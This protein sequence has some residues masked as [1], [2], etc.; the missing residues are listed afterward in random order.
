[1]NPYLVYAI[2]FIAQGFFSAR[3]LTQWILSERA[4]KV[5]SP[6]IF[7]IFSLTGSVL[8]FIYG[9][10][11]DD[12]SIIFGQLITYYIYMESANKGNLATTAMVFAHRRWVTSRCSRCGHAVRHPFLHA[13]LLSQHAS[14]T[15]LTCHWLSGTTHL[16]ASICLSMVLFLPTPCL[17]PPARLLDYQSDR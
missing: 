2:G 10:L 4:K 13:K 8:L 6:N 12:F 9:W 15:L 3:I 16:H 11:R 14:T 17:P 5:L 1:M 7:W